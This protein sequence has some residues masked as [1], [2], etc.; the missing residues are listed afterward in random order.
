MA[1]HFTERCVKFI[2]PAILFFTNLAV[3]L[4]GLT[5]LVVGL[6]SFLHERKYFT[7]SDGDPELTRLPVSMIMV[8]MFVSV[9]SLLGMFG[10]VLI[11]TIGGRIFVGTYAFVLALVIVSEI[12]NGAAAVKFKGQIEQVFIASSTNSLKLYN[13]SKSTREHWDK[14]Q[15]TYKCCGSYNYTAYRSVF[16]NWSVPHSCCRPNV[17]DCDVTNAT[18]DTTQIFTRGCPHAVIHDLEGDLDS[19]TAISFVFGLA[20]ISGIVVA[21]VTL[22]VVTRGDKSGSKSKR[23]YSRLQR[24]TTTS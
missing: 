4:F 7:I 11:R 9:L 14:Y 5:I 23:G 13:T 8:G 6:W 2:L 16:G 3:L 18:K 24:L 15:T 12:G 21:S 19:L 20:Q 17:T 10:A 1:G 22:I